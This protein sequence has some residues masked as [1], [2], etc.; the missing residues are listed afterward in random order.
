M[1]FFRTLFQNQFRDPV[2]IFTDGAG[3]SEFVRHIDQTKRYSPSDLDRLY[4]DFQ[5]AIKAAMAKRAEKKT[6]AAAVPTPAE[7]RA[8]VQTDT[9]IIL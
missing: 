8:Y 3:E 5:K 9:V 4:R 1:V 6:R 2:A 7:L